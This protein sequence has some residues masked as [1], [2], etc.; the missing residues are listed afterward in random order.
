MNLELQCFLAGAVGASAPE[1]VRIHTIVTGGK[2][3]FTWSWS[4]L[5]ASL[6]FAGLGGFIAVV[7][8]SE[9]WHAAFFTGVS[10]PVLINKIVEK[11]KTGR[12]RQHKGLDFAAD[13]NRPRSRFDSFFDGL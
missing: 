12:G 3:G 11:S 6:I 1:I 9:N 7:L 5:A 8:P 13:P 4:Y 10:T 2:Q